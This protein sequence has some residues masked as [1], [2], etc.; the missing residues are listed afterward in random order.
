VSRGR[1]Y[2]HTSLSP[3]I[4]Y[5]TMRG[6]STICQLVCH[7]RYT[8][9]PGSYSANL[10][11]TCGTFVL[12]IYIS[13]I[14]Y[15]GTRS[16]LASEAKPKQVVRTFLPAVATTNTSLVPRE[17]ASLRLARKRSRVWYMRATIARLHPAPHFSSNLQYHLLAAVAWFDPWYSSHQLYIFC[18]IYRHR[19]SHML[20]LSNYNLT[21]KCVDAQRDD[22]SAI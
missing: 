8:D 2:P 21:R 17:E 4:V 19:H 12:L 11:Q 22:S 9:V 3:T 14:C 10:A 6:C 13:R 7:W 16:V 20:L 15:C 18:L 5:A 1:H